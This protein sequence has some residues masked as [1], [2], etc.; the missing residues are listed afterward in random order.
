MAVLIA[1]QERHSRY[2]NNEMPVIPTSL[3][4]VPARKRKLILNS[5]DE[6]EEENVKLLHTEPT[7]LSDQ[8]AELLGSSDISQGL[9]K[10]T[11]HQGVS[12]IKESEQAKKSSRMRKS[13]RTQSVEDEA[14]GSSSSDRC[15]SSENRCHPHFSGELRFGSPDEGRYRRLEKLSK[16]E[17][18]R[19]HRR[20]TREIKGFFQK[21]YSGRICGKPIDKSTCQNKDVKK[22]R[23]SDNEEWD[24]SKEK[25]RPPVARSCNQRKQIDDMDTQRTSKRRRISSNKFL[26]TNFILCDW[27]D[28]EE[29]VVSHI[30]ST[31]GGSDSINAS[32]IQCSDPD[33]VK[34][35]RS[36]KGT[37]RNSAYSA[38]HSSCNLSSSA[39]S[40]SISKVVRK[41]LL[42]SV[43]KNMKLNGK[44]SIKC[45]QCWRVDRRVVVPC[46]MC[47][48]KVYC[49][50]CIK[51]WYP[52]LSEEEVS[53]VCPYCRGNCNCNLC[54]HSASML[55]TS[56]RDISDDEKIRHLY[57][58][59]SKLFPY[60][61][62]IHQEQIEEIEMES[63]IQGVP[64][65][66]V[67]VKHAVC[68]NDERVYCNHCQT[69]IVDLHR[70]CP[71]CS[72]ELCLSCSC[73]IRGGQLPG[74]SNKPIPRYVDRGS[75]YMH[76]GDPLP[77]SCRTGVL[78][79]MSGM[80]VKWVVDDGSVVCPAKEMGGCGSCK[81]E[82]K[83][84]LPEHWIS[85]LKE[86]TGKIMSRCKTINTVLQPTFSNGNHETSYWAASREDFKDNCLYCLDSEDTLNEEALLRFRSHWAKGEPVIVR[87]VLEQT[88][89]LSWEPMVMWRALCE[90]RDARFSSRMSDVKAIDCLA[91]CE[92][93]INT[94]K[95]FTGYIEGRQYANFWPEMLKLKDWPPSDKFEDFLPR[96][97]D[98]FIRALPFQEYTDP[99]TG[100]L[101]LAVKLPASVI[102]PDMGPKTYI[103]YGISEELG[104]GDS[105]TKLHCDMSDAVNILTH[106]AEVALSDEQCQ[107]IKLLKEKH[108]AQ[109]EREC[110]TRR[111]NEGPRP[112]SLDKHKEEG[113]FGG[114]QIDCLENQKKNGTASQAGESDCVACATIKQSDELKATCLS[115]SKHQTEEHSENRGGAL[116]DI[117]RREDVPKLKEYLIKHSNEFRHTYCCPVE[118]VI[119]PIHDQTFYLTSEH[120]V[121]LKEEF[122]IEPW[123]FE[124]KLGEAVFIPA[125]CPH[126]VRNLKSCTKV[127][128]DFVSPENLHECLRL[129]EEFR[130]LPKDHRA[131]EDKLEVK[132]MILHAVNQVIDDLSK[133]IAS[134][135]VANGNE[136]CQQ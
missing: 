106:T 72:Y 105:V 110:R 1:K 121:K 37:K 44:E 126:Q 45:H 83:R 29:D 57:Y 48:E 62:H 123:T 132:K 77:E 66:S 9:G 96:H 34:A 40:S 8:K 73:E 88:S 78:D 49:I 74:G 92:V 93:E 114:P 39:S 65:S 82:L 111:T 87:N 50:Q 13:M 107:A 95:F 17:E 16:R 89:G 23:E 100:F 7:Q 98:E 94:R 134:K 41:K 35:N 122:G 117:F 59:I 31:M 42:E 47:K 22:S 135:G 99:R 68:Y 118:Q 70:S 4:H 20:A 21:R 84:L 130:K 32:A 129:T 113:D 67:E 125:G 36:L 64:S 131:R 56:K 79:R 90:H 30:D 18:S 27:V 11:G 101:N 43:A 124:Q 2:T 28:D 61:E 76:G 58:L 63:T 15:I 25:Q 19:E 60:L 133:L 109:D 14:A 108:R 75:D 52:S 3:K 102:K 115:Y 26:E 12:T 85:G 80:P 33:T 120:K 103:A 116:W 136:H 54:L 97:C 71:N 69:S 10:P 51:Q 119:H 46:T 5:E 6:E 55:K 128:A 81:L 104:R 112:I 24:E 127:A 53:E 86:R 38:K 91:G